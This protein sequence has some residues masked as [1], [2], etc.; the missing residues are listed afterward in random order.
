MAPV[1]FDHGVPGLVC[2]AA[3]WT[4]IVSFF[5]VNYVTHCVTIRQFPGEPITEVVPSMIAALLAPGSGLWRAVNAIIRCP[6]FR[7]LTE[8]RRAA[9][10]GALCIVVRTEDWKPRIGDVIQNISK[11]NTVSGRTLLPNTKP[12][13]TK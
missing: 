6:R 8:L 1:T 4:T 11:P 7:K 5:I 2:V 10:A 9:T 12:H 3:H 13:F